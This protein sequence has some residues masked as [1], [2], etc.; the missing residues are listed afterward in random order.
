MEVPNHDSGF[1]NVSCSLLLVYEMLAAF[2]SVNHLS[3]LWFT[4]YHLCKGTI[5]AFLNPLK[6]VLT[7][8]GLLNYLSKIGTT[9]NISCFVPFQKHRKEGLWV[10]NSRHGDKR[11]CSILAGKKDCN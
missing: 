2:Y 7:I 4:R 11:T 8:D 9:E 6:V 1:I 3:L 5:V 10:I